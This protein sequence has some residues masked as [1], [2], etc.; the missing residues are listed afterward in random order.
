MKELIITEESD[1]FYSEAMRFYKSG[2]IVI[3]S[4]DRIVEE[5]DLFRPIIYLYR[6][7]VELLLKA[8]IIKRLKERGECNWEGLKLQPHNK[9]YPGCIRF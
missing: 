8:F 9:K 6:Q 3:E 5:I 7:A 1:C 2:I 4:K